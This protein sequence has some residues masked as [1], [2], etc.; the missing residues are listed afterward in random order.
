MERWNKYYLHMIFP[1][2]Y[3]DSLQKHESNGPLTRLRTDFFDRRLTRKYNGIIYI[4]N[5]PRSP[6]KNV[7]RSNKRKCFRIKNTRSR[8]YFAETMTDADYAWAGIS[9]KYPCLSQIPTTEPGASKK[10]H[11]SKSER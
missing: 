8:R 10:G 6:I 3:N 1:M 2:R 5:P 9:L 11:W 4:F 7:K